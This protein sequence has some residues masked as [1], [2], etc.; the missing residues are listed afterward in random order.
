MQGDRGDRRI[1]YAGD[2]ARALG[3][4]RLLAGE[5][6]VEDDAQRVEVGLGRQR[7]PA[8]E[9]R[10]HVRRLA[11]DSSSRPVF[12]T[13]DP[14]SRLEIHQVDATVRGNP[15]ILAGRLACNDQDI[16]G[17]DVAV[18]Y[19]SSVD[20]LEEAKISTDHMYCRA[21]VEGGPSSHRLGQAPALEQRL[22][23]VGSSFPESLV[24]N[25]YDHTR[26]RLT[27]E[28]PEDRRLVA[29]SLLHGQVIASRFVG[30]LNEA[31]FRRFRIDYG[32]RRRSLAI[33]DDPDRPI[34]S[35]EV[36]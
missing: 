36:G 6:L 25:W 34:L 35:T 21:G 31:G 19:T 9:F 2:V 10:G 7:L 27:I 18:N 32:E 28:L 22:C 5:H 13:V 12:R 3:L 4:V 11:D 23:E 15:T 1:G 30:E 24:H 14:A 33:G 29:E 16:L 8:S 26:T 20:S 17:T